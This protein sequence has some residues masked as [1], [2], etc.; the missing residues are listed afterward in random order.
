MNPKLHDFK[1]PIPRTEDLIN[2]AM[3]GQVFSSLDLTRGYWQLNLAESAKPFT[4]FTTAFGVFEWNRVP[5]GIHKAGP[6]FQHVVQ[7]IILKDKMFHQ[8]AVYIDDVLVVSK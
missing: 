8:V 1:S 4:A 2:F 5:M 7:N 6:F 3:E